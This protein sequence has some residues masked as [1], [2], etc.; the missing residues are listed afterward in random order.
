MKGAL[1]ICAV[2]SR[3]AVNDGRGL[4]HTCRIRLSRQGKLAAYPR[5]YCRGGTLVRRMIRWRWTNERRVRRCKACG[6]SVMRGSTP[7][8]GWNTSYC[9][10][11]KTQELFSHA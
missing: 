3:Q 11:C 4:C 7:A 8:S 2:C 10:I 9:L 1:I 5:R 6:Q